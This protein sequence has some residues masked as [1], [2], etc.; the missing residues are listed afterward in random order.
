M[1]R[2][3]ALVLLLVK[4]I[5]FAAEPGPELIL[6]GL[7]VIDVETGEV[8]APQSLHI[9]DGMIQSFGPDEAV[10]AACHPDAVVHDLGGRFAV[11]GLWD[12]H[13]HL[14]GGPEL[15]ADNRRWMRQYLGFG[16]TAIRDAG[17]DIPDVVL[18]WKESIA[19]HVISGPRIFSSL[20]KVDGTP[21][22]RRG[23]VELASPTDIPGA[24]NNLRVAGADFVKV[25][26]G[27]FPGSTFLAVLR[28]AR[29]LDLPTAGHVP[30]DV[31][32]E[33]LSTAGLGSI[34]HAY[35]LTKFASAEEM[36]LIDRFTNQAPG[37][38]PFAQYFGMYSSFAASMDEEK[39]KQ[40]LQLMRRSGI[41]ITPTLYL[42][43][44]WFMVD[45]STSAEDDSG[46]FETPESILLT[47]GA[48]GW[49]EYQNQRSPERRSADA[50]MVSETQRL[51]GLAA[52]EGV[53]I[54]AGSDTGTTNTFMYPGDS[55]H[56]ELAELVEAGL[57][58]LQALRAATINAA[59]W[60]ALD[61]EAGSIETGKWADI[62]VLDENPLIDIHNSRS[63]FAVVQFGRLY[64]RQALEQLRT[65]ADSE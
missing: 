30:V 7:S 37:D 50:R 55:L 21:T 54:L 46:F 63:I 38:D 9:R 31:F 32:V 13:V 61:D 35:H 53:V 47:H 23:S 43:R 16:V 42:L 57:S 1:K 33:E 58:P 4:A 12:M 25:N 28:Q 10:S 41:A 52:Q 48:P 14:R 19:K 26:D 44:R 60:F 17:G 29:E 36:Q 34:E 11:P 22:Q 64:D 5:A 6:T 51:V 62:V 49:I 2:F 15:A 45:E 65:L 59:T 20:R 18:S 24:I 39:A 56:N 27:R 8:S 3:T 40:A